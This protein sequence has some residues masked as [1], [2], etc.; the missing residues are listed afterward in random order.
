MI[1]TREAINFQ[2]S[3]IYGYSSQ[4]DDFSVGDVIGPGSLTREKVRQ[5][6]HE[7]IRFLRMYNAILRDFC[8]SEVFSIEFELHSLVELNIP[9]PKSMI[10][11]PG[12]FKDRESLLLALKPDTGYMNMHKSRTSVDKVSKL[13]FEVEEF[14]EHPELNSQEK[15]RFLNKFASRFALKLFGEL[16]ENKWA[17]KLIGLSEA[18]PTEKDMLTKYI[19]I[20]SEYEISWLTR[21]PKIKIKEPKFRKIKKPLEE[22]SILD[23]LK[24]KIS[25]PSAY[26][27]VEKTVQL[28]SDLFNLVN[29]GTID[30]IKEQLI[31]FIVRKLQ[32]E[33]KKITSPYFVNEF[34]PKVKAIL[35]NMEVYFQDFV[36]H[37]NTFLKTGEMGTLLDLLEKFKH[38]ICEKGLSCDNDYE[39]ICTIAIN[40]FKQYIIERE[41][42]RAIDLSS[43]VSY[44]SELIKSIFKLIQEALP[45]Y[46]SRKKLI[47]LEQSFHEMLKEKIEQEQ[48]PA[49]ILGHKIIEK[50]HKY[51]RELIERHPLVSKK[52]RFYDDKLL[53][54]A[55]DSIL[56]ENLDSFFDSFQLGIAD[57]ISFAEEGLGNSVNSVKDHVEKFKAFEKE[58][59]FLMNYILRDSTINRFLKQHSIEELNDPVD[60]LTRFSR[61]LERRM[62]GFNL[63]WDKYILEW[64]QDFINKLEEAML[65][66]ELPFLEV[67][68]QFITYLEER[69]T[70][71]TQIESFMDFL[72]GYIAKVADLE[73]KEVLLEFFKQYE[74][75]LDIKKEFPQYLKRKVKRVIEAFKPINEQ[76][77]L[78]S[79]LSI[80]NGEDFFEFLRETELKYFSKLIPRPKTII[81]RHLLT[82][83]EKELFN[84]ELYHVFEL[85][86][87]KSY[88]ELSVNDNFNRIFREWSRRL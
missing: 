34:M 51:L 86:F 62:G 67:H 8:G 76:Q 30:E 36:E 11:I 84:G 6:S 75:Y 42:L 80:K 85:K 82:N 83:D 37:S 87:L 40:Y 46:L 48:E 68:E 29:T 39:E 64:I 21:P 35:K 88:L 49:R 4:K 43:G 26:F 41:K 57:I 32:E 74:F 31:L 71:E 55:F 56:H 14:S 60:F 9:Y 54:E 20:S 18:L 53:K 73:Q 2:F 66:K 12:R 10:L 19:N 50:Y 23:H 44:F 78:I 5:L 65:Q 69:E 63:H 15:E 17:K 70:Y 77:I 52:T 61:F 81:L 58:L 79:Y 28:G 22:K 59:H 1:T 7:V 27:I 38:H 3:L 13:F 25:E 33:L 24:Y 16:L 72:D 47:E 45:S